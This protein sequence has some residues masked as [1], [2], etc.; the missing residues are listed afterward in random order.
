M[1]TKLKGRT[2]IVTGAAS[3]IGKATALRLA[4]LGINIVTCTRRA[5]L[6][7]NLKKEIELKG[8][9]ALILHGDLT[10]D[11]FTEKIVKSTIEHFG[12]LDILINNAGMTLNKKFEDN[13]LEDF[14]KIMTINV[15]VPF[16]LCQKSIPYLKQSKNAEIIN[17][18]SVVAHKGYPFQ[19]LYTAS[20]HALSGM[21]KSLANEYCGTNIRVHLIAPGGVYTDMVK[22]ARPDLTGEGL[23]MPEDIADVIEFF[24]THRNNSVID[25][26]R[27]HRIGKTPFA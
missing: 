14:K 17:I 2:A 27:V 22:I 15:E 10:S 7:E 13:T 4:K 12:Q 9:K 21:S 6:I 1:Y 25:E 3:G 26:V 5:N 23:I 8:V 24:I 19:S 18:T 20:K 11:G 16:L